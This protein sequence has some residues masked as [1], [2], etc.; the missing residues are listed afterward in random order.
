M[1]AWPYPRVLAHRGGGV[2]APE[3]TIAA[4]RIGCQRGFRGVEFDVTLS[5]DGEPVLMHDATLDRTTDA[6]GP[7]AARPWGEL[8]RL[9][10]GGWFS[11]SFAG[12]PIPRLSDAVGYC[13][14]HQVWI[15]VEIKP[16]AGAEQATG[17]QVARAIARDFADLIG[18]DG[19]ADP[20]VPLLSS[21]SPQALAAARD[22]APSLRRGLL[23]KRIARNWREQLERLQCVALHCDHRT[24]DASAASQVRAAGYWL[25]CYT[26]NDRQRAIE[27]ANWGVDAL[28]TDRLDRIEPTLL[29]R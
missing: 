6:T 27:L 9:D 23:C 19:I 10:A 7:V 4:M 11:S 16:A 29:D 13:R 3:N 20:R 26:V 14:S 28:C 24:L 5:A 17:E 15:N 1:P 22:A 21:F 2:F 18:S 12:E 25:F 8:A